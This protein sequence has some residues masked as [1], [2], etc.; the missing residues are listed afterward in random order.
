MTSK[1]ETIS[2][3]FL[4]IIFIV[5]TLNEES[6]SMCQTRVIPYTTQ[7]HGCCEADEYGIRCAAGKC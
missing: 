3:A 7:V 4:G 6:Y 5:M 1:P 2:G